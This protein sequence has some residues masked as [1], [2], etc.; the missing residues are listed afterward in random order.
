MNLNENDVVYDTKGRQWM[1]FSNSPKFL[2]LKAYI[3][4]KDQY[5]NRST[6][7]VKP[8]T[9][10]LFSTFLDYEAYQLREQ[11]YSEL[12]KFAIDF[13][14]HDSSSTY[15]RKILNTSQGQIEELRLCFDC[16][17]DVLERL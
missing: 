13:R 9:P 1:V 5:A 17:V 12:S 16:L 4:G 2:K 10:T 3:P 8:N 11:F 15:R 6:V 14:S 7:F